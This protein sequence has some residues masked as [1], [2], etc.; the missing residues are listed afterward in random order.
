MTDLGF[1]PVLRLLEVSGG[2]GLVLLADIFERSGEVG[3]GHFHINL[4]VL[5]LDLNLQLGNFL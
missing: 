2:Q 4:H 5:L 1:I 3:L